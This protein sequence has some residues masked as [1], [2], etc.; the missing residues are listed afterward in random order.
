[1]LVFMRKA[2]PR[3]QVLAPAQLPAST[4]AAVAQLWLPSYRHTSSA[5]IHRLTAVRRRDLS[6]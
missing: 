2:L 3:R 4:E 1:M 5:V 6:G